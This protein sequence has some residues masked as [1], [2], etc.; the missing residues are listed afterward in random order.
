MILLFVLLLVWVAFSIKP[1]WLVCLFC[2]VAAMHWTASLH[3]ADPLA[4]LYAFVAGALLSRMAWA[5]AADLIRPR[6]V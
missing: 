3:L 6:P 4:P 1:V 5:L 2:A